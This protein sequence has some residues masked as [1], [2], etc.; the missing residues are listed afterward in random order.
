[1][2]AHAKPEP[3]IVA[4][5]TY[6][7]LWCA[8]GDFEDCLSA[9]QLARWPVASKDPRIRVVEV[10]RTTIRGLAEQAV[11]LLTDAITPPAGIAAAEA[12]WNDRPEDCPCPSCRDQ[13]DRWAREHQGAV[14]LADFAMSHPKANPHL[15]IS[16]LHRLHQ[17]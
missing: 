2:I 13:V 7:Q 8:R 3:E 10:L 16:E 14:T 1:M 11:S 6:N 17:D 5:P 15:S 9:L 12:H 4:E